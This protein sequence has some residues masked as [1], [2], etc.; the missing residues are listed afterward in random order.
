MDG[1]RLVRLN[2][3]DYGNVGGEYATEMENFTRVISV[4]GVKGNPDHFKAYTDDGTII[5]YGNTN[6]NTSNSKRAFGVDAQR[7]CCRSDYNKI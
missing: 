1:E 2:N 3:G 6:G 5:E 4:G 7:K